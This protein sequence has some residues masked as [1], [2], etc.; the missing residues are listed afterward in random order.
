MWLGNRKDCPF[1]LEFI[2][3]QVEFW[4]SKK[5]CGKTSC[6]QVF[7]L[8]FQVLPN[9]QEYFYISIETQTKCFPFLWENTAR[10]KGNHLFISFIQLLIL[11]AH[12]IIMSAL[13]SGLVFLSHRS[14]AKSTCSKLTQN[15][16]AIGERDIQ[17]PP[18]PTV[19]DGMG[20]ARGVSSL[21]AENSL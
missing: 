13:S 1:S 20:C 12:T 16:K 9:F 11:F 4:E 3:T 7:S 2:E 19:T 10:K 15:C 17:S 8:L 14:T 18:Y 5:C 21:P 6:R